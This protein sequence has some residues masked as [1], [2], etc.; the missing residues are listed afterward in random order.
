GGSTLGGTTTVAAVGGMA[1]FGD[2][3]LDKTSSGYG[4]TATATGLSTATSAS[5]TI[6]A[7]TATQLVFGTPPSTTI[8]GREIS[9]AVKV[10]ALDALGNLVPGFT[11]SVSVAL[12][13]N[14]GGG[15]LSGTTPVAAVG[16]V[17]TF[18]D[19]S[20]NKAGSGYTLTAAASGF[21]PVTSSAFD[22]T[23]GTATQLVFT[24]QPSTTVAGAAISPAVQVSALDAANNVV[25][26]FTG[27]VTVALGNN[28]GGSTLGGTTTVAAVGGV[29]TFSNLSLDK[30]SSGYG[31]TAT[32]AGL[33][34][35]TSSSFTITAGTAT[36][37]VF[38]TP[39]STTIAG[40]QISPAVKVRALDAL[41]NVATGFTGDVTLALGANPGGGT[42]S[43]TNPVAAVSG[44]AT[45]FDL[46]INKTGTGYTLTASAGGGLGPITS[47]PFDIVPG[48]A[49]QLVFA[50][51]PTSTVAGQ[52]ITPAVQ[53]SALDPAGN[54]VPTF[55]GTVTIA[56]GNNPGGSTLG[57]T[58]TVSAVNGIATFGDLSLDKTSTGYW[59][60][61][62][63]AGLSSARSVSFNITAGPATQL[64]WGTQPGT[65][66]G[67]TIFSPAVKVRALDALGNLATDFTE[68]VTVAFG[69]NPG[70]QPLVGTTTV[71]AVGGVAT[72]S[73]LSVNVAATGYTLTANATGFAPVTSVSFDVLVGPPTHVDFG[74]H[75]HDE[76][77][78]VVIG[79][80][81]VRLRVE[82]AGGNL[83]TTATNAV[84]V[85]LGAN[86][87]GGTLSGTTTVNAVD[88]LATF[89]D[90]TLD[91]V[92]IGY[93][94][95]FTSP[96]L[97]GQTSN[98]FNISPAAAARVVFTVQPT[99]TT[100]GSIITPAV[101]VTAQD[102]FGNV[103]TGF[104]GSVTVAIGNNPG[105]STLGGTTTIASV[106]GVATFSDLT[107]NNTGTGY[108]L[109]ALA[110]SLTGDTTASFDIN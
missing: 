40:R 87:G 95:V 29:A 67:G 51:Q 5:F 36:Q 103:A 86:P 69:A 61:V 43:G 16:G 78:G 108:T 64:V 49:T 88:G 56:L 63:A 53:V 34:S 27:P 59:L 21:A 96:G 10:R 83:V 101:Q 62:T 80:P 44:V 22:I 57:G 93:T 107:I 28:P 92:G 72:F 58:T 73:P 68:T 15:T 17:A 13:A 79:S 97:T 4:L 76:V 99:S 65:I 25:P 11:G 26:S 77:A 81:F 91:K 105:S 31:L 45:F 94:L 7:G 100:A 24:V 85:A 30:T 39:P 3:T 60:T 48:N 110:G 66:T 33:S 9:P 82:D 2:L 32:A 41:G 89:D 14:P 90:L 70:G 18:F 8:A 71:A 37:L 35:T 75:P 23:P 47:T 55:A 84:S 102:Q 74:A 104:A 52:T 20:I 42:L 54:P 6:T 50:G 46:S 106:G 98:T 19:L 38:G 12:G 109:T 1:S